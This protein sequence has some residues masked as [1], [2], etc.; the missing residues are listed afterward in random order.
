MNILFLDDDP[1][2][3]KRFKEVVTHAQ[4]ASDA[5]GIITL[6]KDT[7]QTDLLFL[8]HDLGGQT[9][10]DSS[11]TNTGMEVVRWIVANKPKINVIVVHSLNRPAAG[12]MVF[13][14]YD[15]GYNVSAIP[16]LHLVIYNTPMFE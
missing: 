10:V 8:D 2:R 9:F 11:E 1:S 14:L 12:E 6:L 3:T 13:K 4:C 15:V 7:E 16:F 5:E